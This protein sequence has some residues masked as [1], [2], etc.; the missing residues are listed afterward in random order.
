MCFLPQFTPASI[1]QNISC[2]NTIR[3]AQW[4]EPPREAV[5]FLLPRNDQAKAV[6]NLLGKLR[7]ES[8]LFV[9]GCW[10][11]PPNAF[12]NS[13]STVESEMSFFCTSV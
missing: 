2:L 12:F 8:L 9:E 3:A 6:D 11:M 13:G 10:Q 1:P 4:A 7:K 5:S